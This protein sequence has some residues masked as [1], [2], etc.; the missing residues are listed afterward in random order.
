[1]TRE[2]GN[3]KHGNHSRKTR[4][5]IFKIFLIQA[6]TC[7]LLAAVVL[8]LTG[9]VNA[10]SVLLGGGLY[11]IPSLYFADRA[12]RFSAGQTA[13]QALAQMYTSQIWKMALSAC[14]F[15]AVFIL[16]QPVNPFS[17]FGT[18]VLM[19]IIG[20]YAQMKLNTRFLKL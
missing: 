8:L 2:Q 6:V 19:Q 12:L 3:R 1:M 18:F 20:W 17:L 15:A 10:Y 11:L 14:G 7:A 16:I 4:K 5:S 13:K 9:V